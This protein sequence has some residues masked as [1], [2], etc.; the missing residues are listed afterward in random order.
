MS[1][2]IKFYKQSGDENTL[3]Y[4]TSAC[5]IPVPEIPGNPVNSARRPGSASGPKAESACKEGSATV[6]DKILQTLSLGPV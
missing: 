1:K 5:K 4:A 6:V 2:E 3:S